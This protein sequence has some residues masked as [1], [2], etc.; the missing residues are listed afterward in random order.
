MDV[1]ALKA[2]GIDVDDALKR[3]MGNEN[4]LK[5]M[6]SKF[7]A[8]TTFTQLKSATEEKDHEKMFRCAHTLKGISGNLSLTNLYKISCEQTELFRANKDDEGILMMAEVEK[9][10]NSVCEVI[11]T[12]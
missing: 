4:L 5:R 2:A 7:L 6:L 3:F 11:K 1:K 10:Y 12:I 8:D 9:A